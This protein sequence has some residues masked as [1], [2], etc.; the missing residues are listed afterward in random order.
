M[1][2]RIDLNPSNRP[3]IQYVAITPRSAAGFEGFALHKITSPL[4][5]G[6]C[7]GWYNAE[8]KLLD[9]EQYPRFD[10]SRPVKR[11]GPIWRYCERQG[12]IYRRVNNVAK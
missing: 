2:R 6:T 7:S 8:G 5:K 3:A 4:F 11:G 12:A 10:T 1:T 9:A